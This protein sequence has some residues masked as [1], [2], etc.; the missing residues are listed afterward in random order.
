MSV[1][2]RRWAM[3]FFFGIYMPAMVG[4]LVWF[5]FFHESDMNRCESAMPGRAISDTYN[6]N[7][8]ILCKSITFRGDREEFFWLDGD[9]EVLR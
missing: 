2:A 8:E 3:I 5:S 1:G 9:G 4:I 7:G 6:L